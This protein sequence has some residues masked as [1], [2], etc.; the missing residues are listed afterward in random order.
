MDSRLLLL[1]LSA[2]RRNGCVLCLGGALFGLLS[3][4]GRRLIRSSFFLRRSCHHRRRSLLDRFSRFLRL[5]IRVRCGRFCCRGL[6]RLCGGGLRVTGHQILHLTK[7]PLQ[8]PISYRQPNHQHQGTGYRQG[9]PAA[10][11]LLFPGA[12]REGDNLSLLRSGFRLL[13]ELL[14]HRGRVHRYLVVARAGADLFP[15][16]VR[17]QTF[18]KRWAGNGAKRLPEILFLLVQ[19]LLLLCG[20][21]L[22]FHRAMAQILFLCQRCFPPSK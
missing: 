6:G 18:G 1:R 14:L 4:A 17:A 9:A 5:R 3:T 13:P 10:R 22:F 15:H 7:R 21:G 11:T 8:L 12:L 19:L 16:R 2:L 20:K